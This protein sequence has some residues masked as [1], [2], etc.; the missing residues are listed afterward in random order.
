MNTKIKIS[1]IALSFG[2]VLMSAPVLAQEAGG[3]KIGGDA[4]IVGQGSNVTTTAINESTASTGIA[5]VRGNTDVG[6][7]V[8]VFGKA[9]NVTT[10]AV[11]KSCAETTIGGIG[12]GP[13]KR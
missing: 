9:D 3:V 5:V 1:L 13:C 6:G 2:A 4:K 12:D 10:K 11:N 8:D 7:D